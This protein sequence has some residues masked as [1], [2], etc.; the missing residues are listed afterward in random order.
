M[1][2][3]FSSSVTGVE[4]GTDPWSALEQ[5]RHL[6]AVAV[7]WERFLGEYAQWFKSAFLARGAE[8]V[9]SYPCP[10]D[11]G[12]AH[13]VVS[14]G[15][16]DLE[17]VCACE[18]G[19]CPPFALSPEDL[20]PW[21]LSWPRFG[22]SLS[23]AL[24]LSPAHAQ[25]GLPNTH[26]V[27]SW[28]VDAVPAIVTLQSCPDDFQQVA[29]ALVARLRQPFILLAPSARHLDASS[30]ELLGNVGA[31]FFALNHH[32]LV[33]G[34]GSL[35]CRTSPGEL[36]MRFAPE[37]RGTVEEDEA[38]KAFALVKTLDS[39]Q[40]CRRASLY[41]VFR[42]YCVEGFSAE[43]VA[44][45]CRC[46]RAIIFRR[47]KTL[48]DKLGTHPRSLRHIS[49]HLEQIETSISDPRAR[50]VYRKGAIY[51]DEESDED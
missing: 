24:G 7:T 35:Q 19:D 32:L 3:D 48:E 15:P 5:V 50:R 44:R 43:E 45:R 42:L 18:R 27:G 17:A 10:N 46:T 11:C 14:H 28:S 20:L 21:D 6:S 26:Q 2:A 12:C 40:P 29:A 36:F 4:R 39:A 30:K 25:F 51:G 47:L 22:R 34:N 37:S 13:E 9:R 1:R 16:A 33:T 31:A 49:T 41:R 38:R 8:P 23:K